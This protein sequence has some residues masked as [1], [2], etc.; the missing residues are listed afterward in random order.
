MRG[1][2]WS[3]EEAGFTLEGE[4]CQRLHRCHETYHSD[5]SCLEH[6]WSWRVCLSL[7]L[8]CLE[9]SASSAHT[10]YDA[11]GDTLTVSMNGWLQSCVDSRI[12]RSNH[13][14]SPFWDYWETITFFFLFFS[15]FYL[16]HYSELSSSLAS[17]R[18]E[19]KTHLLFSAEWFVIFFPLILPLY[20]TYQPITVMQCVCVCVIKWGYPYA[21]V[22]TL[23]SDYKMGYH[24]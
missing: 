9:S 24:K 4:G 7:Q 6:D 1:R 17:S 5:G 14:I 19:L 2:K 18:S 3:V 20:S 21:F 22:S 12:Y 23:G 16:T 8:Y 13:K 15:N 10:Q 11:Y